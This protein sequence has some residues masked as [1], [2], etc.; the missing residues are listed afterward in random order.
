MNIFYLAVIFSFTIAF[1]LAHYYALKKCLLKDWGRV[2]FALLALFLIMVIVSQIQLFKLSEIE[3]NGDY[4]SIFIRSVIEEISKVTFCYVLFESIAPKRQRFSILTFCT[5]VALY[6]SAEPIFY[7]SYNLFVSY[8]SFIING[9]IGLEESVGRLRENI[10]ILDTL[11]VYT[12]EIMRIPVHFLLTFSGVCFLLNKE[13][14]CLLFL[15]LATH[16]I[17]NLILLFLAIN[18]K[19]TALFLLLENIVAL[20]TIALLLALLN[21]QKFLT[22]TMPRLSHSKS[23]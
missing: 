13:K 14:R 17:V 5:I 11:M 15:P 2:C 7:F 12:F 22:V 6:E 23:F 4:L 18:V 20:S 1:C 10:S 3:N 21:Q 19:A 8:Q 16:G 9:Q